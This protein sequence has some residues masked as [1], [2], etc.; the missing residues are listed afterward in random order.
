MMAAPT[1]LYYPWVVA[2]NAM[3]ATTSIINIE[4]IRPALAQLADQFPLAV[5]S[6]LI[7]TL[8]L[9]LSIYARI[10]GYYRIYKVLTL[11]SIATYFFC[12]YATP[13]Y[14]GPVRCLQNFA[15]MKPLSLSLSRFR[16]QV[17]M[18]GVSC[19]R[20]DENRGP[21]CP[22]TRPPRVLQTPAPTF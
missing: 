1:T 4:E 12:P 19:Y 18:S 6:L 20:H 21:L 15:S 3:N 10:S 9:Y 5:A 8:F 13:I 14:C 22:P 11:S 17:L 2:M 16:P 7:P